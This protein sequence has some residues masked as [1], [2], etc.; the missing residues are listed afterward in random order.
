MTIH[1]TVIDCIPQTIEG[2]KYADDYEFRMTY[3]AVNVTREESTS[4]IILTTEY[5][6]DDAEIDNIPKLKGENDG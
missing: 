3:Y 6:I 1:R 2:Q 5:W 4:H